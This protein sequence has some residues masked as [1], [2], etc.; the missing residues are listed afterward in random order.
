MNHI[1]TSRNEILNQCKD[2]FIKNG[3]ASLNIRLVA[4]ECGVSTGTIY[5][6]FE[7][8]TELVEAVIESIWNEIFQHP[9]TLDTISDCIQWL[10]DCLDYGNQKYPG[11]F[12]FHS[13]GNKEFGKVRM[14]E[15]WNHILECLTHVLKSDPNI[16][17]CVFNEQFTPEK[18]A[19]I[20]FSIFLAD[21]I[22]QED[23]R[24]MLLE[25]IKRTVY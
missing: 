1:I 19:N 23:N 6:Y 17:F 2:M 21:M 22:R 8:K 15:I 24:E 25:M 9:K 18:Y 12:T 7:S 3:H 5:N 13:F 11:F 10:Y 16:D 14:H 4:L 20:I